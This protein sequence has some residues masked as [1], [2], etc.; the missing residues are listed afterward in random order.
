MSDV[1]FICVANA[2]RSVMAER[3]FNRLAGGRHHARSA[4]S[5][6]G[7]GPH[8][9]VVAALREV[10]IDAAGHVPRNLDP[11]EVRTVDAVVSTC[12]EEA[13]PVTPPGTRRIAWSLPDPK[14]LPLADVRE[15][16]DE[17][18][19][20]VLELLRELDAADD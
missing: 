4:G 7:A 2:G 12:G 18:E 15:L 8:D 17:I 5:E 20:R 14:G 3:L 13:C 10:G 11:D 19:R 6:P 1:L 9:V 16:R